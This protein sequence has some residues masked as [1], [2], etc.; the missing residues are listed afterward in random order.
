MKVCAITA[1]A[2]RHFCIERSVGLFLN[3]TYDNCIQLIYQN[4][5]VYQELRV[6]FEKQNKIILINENIDSKTGEPYKT[7]G[8]IYN[9]ALRYIPE[10]IDIITFW[11]DDDIFMPNHIEE[12]VRGY[13]RAL[14]VG[15]ISYKPSQSYFRHSGGV[16][17]A[18]N[19]L[20]PSIFTKASF[21]Q[22]YGF[23]D[24][25][26]DQHLKWVNPLTYQ[27]KIF[28]DPNGIPTL[29]YNWGD[30]FFTWKTSGDP[31]NPENF[32]NYRKNSIDHGDKIITPLSQEIIQKYYNQVYNAHT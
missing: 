23:S 4:S 11:D 1:T 5:D 24:T 22:E 30:D 19:T 27:Q 31:N 7:L 20:E 10:D 17:L 15:K 28:V 2:G 32:N 25:T 3:Q 26:S 6:P 21:I 8:A 12:G 18:S 9:D 16:N 29:I 13:Q 14:N